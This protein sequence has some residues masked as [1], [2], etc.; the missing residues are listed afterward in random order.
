VATTDAGLLETI[1]PFDRS[2]LVQAE[3]RVEL[4]GPLPTAGRV[5]CT[6]RLAGIYDKGSGAL[7][8]MENDAVDAETNELM[9]RTTGSGFIR[10][11]GG[12][13][14]DRGPSS[15]GGRVPERAPDHVVAYDTRVEQA[16]LYRL[17]GDRNPLHLLRVASGC[18][19]L[20]ARGECGRAMS[21]PHA[22][23]VPVTNQTFLSAMW[24]TSFGVGRASGLE[25]TT[26]CRLA[27]V[28]GVRGTGRDPSSGAT[29]V[30]WMLWAPRTRSGSS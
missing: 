27:G 20:V 15:P 3:Q 8:V 26:P 12:W 16:L 24:C 6:S 5:R 14:G 28:R 29:P 18:D 4:V 30:A 10:G 23:A 13:G 19:D 1:G 7:V 11:P 21:T 22:A 2:M 17:S 9:F 25:K